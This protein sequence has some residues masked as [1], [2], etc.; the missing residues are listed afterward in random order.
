MNTFTAWFQKDRTEHLIKMLG[1]Q[2]KIIKENNNDDP[3]LS[4]YDGCMVE[5]RMNSNID[6]LN[7]YHAGIMFGI[8]QMR[9]S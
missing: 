7:L 5:I 8:S 4:G 9:N 1:D 2:I 6:M 3:E